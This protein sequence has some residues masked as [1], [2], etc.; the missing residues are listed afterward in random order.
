MQPLCILCIII[1]YSDIGECLTGAYD[2]SQICVEADGGYECDCYD[3][4]ELGFD[5]VTCDG[6][7]I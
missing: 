1:I 2:C 7:Y 6:I 5:G 3:G 4:Y